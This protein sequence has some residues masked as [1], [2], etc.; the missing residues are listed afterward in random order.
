[1]KYSEQ[2][3]LYRQKYISGCLDLGG[4]L[5]ILGSAY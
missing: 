4:E 2:A 5:G 3:D 1:M